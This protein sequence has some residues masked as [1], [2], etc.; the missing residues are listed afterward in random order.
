MKLRWYKVIMFLLF[1]VIAIG[2]LNWQRLYNDLNKKYRDQMIKLL[3]VQDLNSTLIRQNEV[4]ELKSNILQKELDYHKSISTG[5][6]EEVVYYEGILESQRPSQKLTH[7]EIILL[8][9]TAQAEAGPFKGHEVSQRMV[10]KC[11]LNRLDSAKYPDTLKG[12]IYDKRGGTQFSVAYDGSLDKVVLEDKTLIN[13]Y[14]VVMY[15]YDMPFNVQYFY[16]S[17][18]GEGS[19]VKSLAVYKEVQGTVFAYN[20]K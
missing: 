11:I 16:A 12:V 19:W 14:E 6:Q 15:G 5:L 2:T 4:L 8:A 18:L 17:Y 3:E 20:H 1:I 13:V 7:E 9:K 10:T